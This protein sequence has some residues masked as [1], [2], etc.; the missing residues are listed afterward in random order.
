[1]K[2]ARPLPLLR[3]F[4]A[5]AVVFFVSLIGLIWALL[6]DGI[7]DMFA[8]LAVAVSVIVPA[9]WSLRR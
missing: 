3:V 7:P 6:V 5:P 1:M 8:S 2:R 4:L 9:W